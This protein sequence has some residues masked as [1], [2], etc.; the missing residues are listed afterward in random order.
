[1]DLYRWL[2]G[3]TKVLYM[4]YQGIGDRNKPQKF[5]GNPRPNDGVALLGWAMGSSAFYVIRHAI[6]SA[7]APL[8]N[9]PLKLRTPFLRLVRAYPFGS[10]PNENKIQLSDIFMTRISWFEDSYK[11]WQSP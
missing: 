6:L 1:M 11:I 5:I 7:S 9:Q 10:S 2:I 4:I 3:F 8:E